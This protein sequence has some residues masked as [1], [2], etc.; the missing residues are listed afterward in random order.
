MTT[1][2]DYIEFINKQCEEA[3]VEPYYIKVKT[4]PRSFD[5]G[6]IRIDKV[7]FCVTL[8]KGNTQKYTWNPIITTLS[9]PGETTFTI[10]KVDCLS[11]RE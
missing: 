3:G 10:K 9:H 8:H 5:G 7:E 4:I 6:D 2:K 1:L 11:D